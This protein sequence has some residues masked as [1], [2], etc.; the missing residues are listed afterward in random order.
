MILQETIKIEVK[1]KLTKTRLNKQYNLNCNVDDIVDVPWR[2]FKTSSH[3]RVKILIECDNCKNQFYRRL[4]D[5]KDENEILCAKCGKLGVKNPR[6][7]KPAHPNSIK[8][9]IKWM[10]ENGN[11]F[12]NPEISNNIKSRWY[13][14]HKI[15]PMSGHK[16]SEETKQKQSDIALRQ[17]VTGER[18]ISHRYGKIYTRYYKDIKYQ[19]SNELK[20]LKYVDELG[21]LDFIDRGPRISYLYEGKYHSYF[22]DYM[23]KNTDVV[24]E[25]KSNY[26]W[27]KNIVVNALKKEFAEKKYKYNL[28]IDNKFDDIKVILEEECINTH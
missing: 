11:P 3:R 2:D 14:I 27:N 23:I 8:G 7:G 12:S 18:K 17:F 13:E 10:K 9:T 22:I 28:I 15:P 4:R 25:I 16:H 6:F 1:S 21:Y 24:F 26:T 19:S 20:F 5:I